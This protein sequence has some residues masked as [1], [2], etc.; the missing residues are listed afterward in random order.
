[1][2]NPLLGRTG[3]TPQD[4]LRT[5]R[6]LQQLKNRQPDVGKG[7][8]VLPNGDLVVDTDA[9]FVYNETP[10][11]AVD[12]TNRVFT[13]AVPYRAGTLLVQLNGVFMK[14]DEDYERIGADTLEF[15]VDQTPQTGDF[16]VV[17]YEKAD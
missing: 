14:Q 7:L 13:T 2:S 10:T 8:E 3:R 5:R 17:H 4:E 15:H 16:I 6:A 1:M 12:G 9:L 11:G